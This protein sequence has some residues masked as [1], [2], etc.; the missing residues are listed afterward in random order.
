MK[1]MV[2]NRTVF[3][4]DTMGQLLQNVLYLRSQAIGA[5]PIAPVHSRTHQI[6][7]LE[8]QLGQAVGVP[9]RP[10]EIR[11]AVSPSLQPPC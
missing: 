4:R 1:C 2:G 3:H 8:R 11:V 10:D 6:R 5:V 9:I 7:L